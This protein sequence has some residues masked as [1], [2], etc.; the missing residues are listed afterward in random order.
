MPLCLM[1]IEQPDNSAIRLK[2]RYDQSN[3]QPSQVSSTTNDHSAAVY[4]VTIPA[5][6]NYNYTS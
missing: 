2:T 5:N 6:R 1:L 3:L 4:E